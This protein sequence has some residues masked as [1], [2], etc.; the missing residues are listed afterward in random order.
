MTG[1][2]KHRSRKKRAERHHPA[3]IV[4]VEQRADRKSR[5]TRGDEEE[6]RCVRCCR[7]GEPA[8]GDERLQE[9]RQVVEDEAAGDGVDDEHRRN[10]VPAV[11][12]RA[13]SWCTR[14]FWRLASIHFWLRFVDRMNS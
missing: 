12:D 10:A 9:N 13:A 2:G 8:L 14:I 5:D 4:A 3:W 11:E 6:R 1:A 7:H